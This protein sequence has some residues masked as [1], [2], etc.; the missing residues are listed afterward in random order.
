VPIN[1][2]DDLLANDGPTSSNNE[3]EALLVDDK[4]QQKSSLQQ[5]MFVAAKKEPDRHAQVLELSKQTNLPAA[6]V[7]RKFDEVSRSVKQKAPD[8]DRIIEETPGLAKWLED[9]DNATLARDDLEATGNIERNAKAVFKAKPESSFFD[10]LGRAGKTG[11]NDLSSSSWHMAAAYGKVSP[12]EAAQKVAEHNKRS[13]ELRAQMPDYAKDFQAMLD[14][15]G[16]DVN[17]AS[18]QFISS[19]ETYKK[20]ETLKA[21]RD[22]AEGG[23]LTVGEAVDLISQIPKSPKGLTYSITES[24]VASLPSLVTSGAGAAVG[25]VPGMVGGA[26]VGTAATEIGSQINESLTK[27]GY[28]LTNPDDIMKAYRDPKLMAEIKGEAERKGLTTAAVE[29]FFTV[30]A[31]KSL[32]AVKGKGLVAGAKGVVKELAIDAT[33]EASG[34]F[35]GQL[36]REQGR[37]EN[38]DIGGSISE[39]MIG[40]GQGAGQTAIGASA[41][42]VFS[43]D[44]AT[45]AQ[46]VADKT[47][48]AIQTQQQASGLS[49]MAE[50]IKKLKNVT[51]VPG[52]IRELVDH[53]TGEPVSIFFQS[54]DW[55]DH[56]NKQGLSPAK[57]AA[58]IMGDNGEAYF[59]AKETGAQLELPLGAFMENVATSEHFQPLLEKSRSKPD[60][61]TLSESQEHMDSLPSTM[62]DLAQEALNPNPEVAQPEAT[63]VEL[64]E[65]IKQQLLS[66]GKYSDKEAKTNAL[67]HQE[68]MGTF[69]KRYGYDPKV[70]QEKY[71]LTVGAGQAAEGE[72]VLNQEAYHGTFEEFGPEQLKSS[73][74]GSY[75][76]GF[77]LTEDRSQA[78]VY[79]DKILEYNISASNL[80]DVT[81]SSISESVRSFS[82]KHGLDIS[83]S[84]MGKRNSVFWELINGIRSKFPDEDMVGTNA[85]DRLHE[86]LKADGFEGIR[87]SQNGSDKNLLIFDKSLIKTMDGK[88]LYQSGLQDEP[89]G[90]AELG[91]LEDVD[92]EDLA[93]AFDH[94]ALEANR[95]MEQFEVP[96]LAGFALKAPNQL[97]PKK[98]LKGEP[99]WLKSIPR[100]KWVEEFKKIHDRDISVI[101][102][103]K[104]KGEL[105][106]TVVVNGSLSDGYARTHLAH[107]LGESV[108]VVIYS[109]ETTLYQSGTDRK[110]NSPFTPPNEVQVTVVRGKLPTVD[111]VKKTI[112]KMQG[113]AVTNTAT[114]WHI[115]F[116]SKGVG[117]SQQTLASKANRFAGAN[118]KT[119][120]ENAV[121]HRTEDDK[122]GSANPRHIFYAPMRYGKIEAV[123]KIVVRDENGKKFY[124]KFALEKEKPQLSQS[125]LGPGQTQTGPVGQTHNTGTININDFLSDIKALQKDDPFFQG[126]PA[127][128]RGQIRFGADRKFNIDLFESADLST[129]LH[130]SGHFYMEVLADLATA[131][132]APEQL[133]KDFQTILDWM[134][135]GSREEIKVEHHEMWARSF[136]AYLMTGKA[137]SSALREA[138]TRFKMWLISVYRRVKLEHNLT[139]EIRDV[140]NRMLA[141]DEEIQAAFGEQNIKPLFDNPETFGLKGEKAERYKQAVERAEHAAQ[142]Q[143]T[144]KLMAEHERQRSKAY[145]EERSKIREEIERDVN[146]Q[147]IF[148]ALSIIQRGKLADGSPLPAGTPD[149][150]KLDREALIKQYGKVFVSNLPKPYVYAKSGGL[151]HDVV[152]EMLGFADGDDL[153][154]QIATAPDKKKLIDQMTDA[155]MEEL[156]PDL[157]K[158]RS[159]LS[160]EAIAAIHNESR[161]ELLR[162]ELEYLL[163]EETPVSKDMIRQVA[164][165]V[166]SNKQVKEQAAKII[167]RRKISEI[168]PHLFLSA[169]KKAAK[170]AGELL[171]QGDRDGA[172]EA[173]KKEL[174]NH[175][176]YMAAVAAKEDFEKTLKK[177]KKFSKGD[178]DLAKTRDMDL[179]NAARAILTHFGIGK[180][181]KPATSFLEQIKQ[182]DPDTYQ[183]VKAMVDSAT[184]IIGGM[185]RR[186]VFSPKEISYDDFVTLKDTI[187]AIW[188]LSKSTREMEIDGQKMDREQIQEELEL[189]LDELTKPGARTGYDKAA[190]K[191]DS[192]KIQLLGAKAALTRV[193]SWA[194]A[195]D[196]KANKVFTKY[197][198]RPI[199]EATTQYR[200]AKK[201]HLQKFLE[202]IKP[203]EKSLV[204]KEIKASELGYTFSGKG[205]L[206]GALLHTGNES[207]LSKLLRGREWG[208]VNEDGTLDR[209]KWDQFI[210]RMWAEGVLSK[211]D[212]DVVQSIWDLF[213]STKPDAQKAHK[214]MYGHYFS[215][216]TANEITTPFGKYRGGYAPAM[217][218]HVISQDAAIRAD[219]DS[220]EGSNNS[221]MFPTA[222]RGFTKSR[223]DQYA[224][225]LVMDLRLVPTH[226]DK[227]LR[228]THIESTVKDI[229]RIIMHK[230]FR[231]TLDAFD[232][233]V[234]S[235][236]LVPWLQ[237]AATQKVST[238]SQGWAGKATDNFFK[239]LRKRAGLNAMVGNV[240]NTMQQV[241]GLSIAAVKVSPKYLRNSLWNYVKSPSKLTDSVTEKSDFM[242]TRVTAQALE[243]QGH[244]EDLLL[245]PTKYEEAR[246]FAEKHGYFLQS[247]MQN[248]VD[249]IVWS[250]AYE[251]A[252]EQNLTE[253][254]AVREA[255]SAVRMTQGSF[256][257]E[258]ISRF[259]S[260]SAFTRAFT[261]F[262]SFFNGQANLLG[263]EFTSTV[264]NLGLKKGAGRLLYVYLFGF[265]I[266]AMM[267]EAIV[268]AMSGK[269]LDED[270]DDNYLDDVMALF[271][272]S[273]FRYGTAMFPIIGPAT[274]ATVNTFNDK[275]YDDR[276]TTSPAISMIESAVSAPHSVYEAIVNDGKEKRAIRDTLSF[277][278]LVSGLPVAPLSRPLGYLQDYS[279]GK[280]RPSGPVDFTRG[281]ITGKS[282]R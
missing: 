160:G 165:R 49:A 282:G 68:I 248:V 141:T 213:E 53:A 108:P 246:R 25:G 33:G 205:E 117:K 261:M 182:Y 177:F 214:K 259:E 70:L 252:V 98:H 178:E 90:F 202:I 66:T 166:P 256:N 232:P 107:A 38:V 40:L 223:V 280:A 149:S 106:P 28:D 143:L 3:Y 206:L 120:I 85:V 190:T 170:E 60:G 61:M 234:G 62:E 238:P 88:A 154:T 264:R 133:K 216:V 138:F 55:D 159:G 32:G 158:N 220:L 225:P 35:A 198:V 94:A 79:G 13:A 262:Y 257:A 5:S 197:I 30:F 47:A 132:D 241:T 249:L 97:I 231:K 250:G 101:L 222:G 74:K 271:F 91:Y 59:E 199:Q 16:G 163:S 135:V 277:I 75:G 115:E 281:L 263:S 121:H 44:T 15:E 276:I 45:A 29:S 24:L 181:D 26:F 161:S 279:D 87:F 195:M 50:E 219:K 131:E 80:F 269:G 155:R 77:Y 65:Q 102:E 18:E 27:R 93:D 17:K 192:V 23:V 200:M 82:K 267:S 14:K 184:E 172:Y 150:M 260:G 194:Q 39:G 145:K 209:R 185:G 253:K 142:E 37:I 71:G 89:V 211:E 127:K 1:E 100:E 42:G 41:R 152:A 19:Y 164:K 140:M 128:P 235:D 111:A 78:F 81:E 2:Y 162:M 21:L 239:E 175:E 227:V 242:K 278:G 237:R 272:G 254:E 8:Y 20:G 122:L 36:A 156:H 153:V 270:D 95:N 125:K 176:L 228:F 103:A 73:E 126:N 130:E 203:I 201:D 64:G 10:D 22:F 104:E 226:L 113:K 136:E 4:L 180:I 137:P 191:W 76:P 46:E 92:D 119:L 134:G 31:G 169:E 240:V 69:R 109:S 147:K 186:R 244:I 183:T 148:R 6:L 230:G 84:E 174:L 129:F 63:E 151:H 72:T 86:L 229:S 218:D 99:G 144:A 168:K 243:I 255:D 188:D 208:S 43:K 51:K 11:W 57:A 96:D 34:E 123:V 207:N 266:P 54:A 187:Q 273:Q 196:E 167:A 236:L 193:E 116:S 268:K 67:L 212:Y 139:P 56:W 112:D 215:E 258:D 118:L 9:P 224:A 251:Q 83:R 247:G 124:D 189:R 52:K 221:F 233:T 274:S 12:E 146:Q 171:A 179:V 265:M 105:A 114:G 275:P 210:S 245:N 204:K 110:F 173:K 157:L 217:V 48:E 7:E 58:E